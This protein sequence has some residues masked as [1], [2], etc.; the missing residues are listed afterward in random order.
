M[1][2]DPRRRRP[3]FEFPGSTGAGPWHISLVKTEW[4]SFKI[5][6]TKQ[7]SVYL[8]VHA[9][10]MTELHPLIYDYKYFSPLYRKC[11]EKKRE[12]LRHREYALPNILKAGMLMDGKFMLCSSKTQ[13]IYLIQNIV[14]KQC[15]NHGNF[16]IT[17]IQDGAEGATMISFMELELIGLL[18]R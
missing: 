6:F 10:V 1:F 5:C 8:H 3:R 14:S 2:L 7:I 17:G 15:S 12:E 11:P 13:K 9:L 18:R 16:R 4:I